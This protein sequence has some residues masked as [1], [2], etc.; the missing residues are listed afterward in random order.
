[1]NFVTW[2]D[3]SI[4]CKPSQEE[5]RDY[6]LPPIYTQVM[7]RGYKIIISV[8]GKEYHF[9][10]TYGGLPFFCPEERRDRYL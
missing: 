9:H 8:G 4:G 2:S 1:M 5:I 6:D 7:I 3:G 10:G